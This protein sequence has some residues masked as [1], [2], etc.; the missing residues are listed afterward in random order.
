MRI[1]RLGFSLSYNSFRRFLLCS[2]F[3][4]VWF[5]FSSFLF[6]KIQDSS[7]AESTPAILVATQKYLLTGFAPFQLNK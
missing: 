1:Y 4:I 5:A 7:L 6:T 2:F 3:F